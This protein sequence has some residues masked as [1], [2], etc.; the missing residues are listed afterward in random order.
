MELDVVYAD[1]QLVVVNKP[2]GVAVQPDRSGDESLLQRVQAAFPGE[3][4]GSPHRLDRPVGGLVVFTRSAAALRGMDALFRERQVEKVYLAVVEG[5]LEQEG[6]LEHRL[7][8]PGGTRKATVAAAGE[9]HAV[10][11]RYRVRTQGDRYSLL[12]VRPEGGAFHQIRAQ[13]AAA[14]HP[15]KGDVKYG[16]RRGEKDRSIALHAW[17]L[18]FAHPATGAEVLAEAAPPGGGIWAKLMDPSA[19]K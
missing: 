2:P 6:T 13:L 17:R 14:G 5:R 16:A 10:R 11:V 12:E 9:G 4:I 3:H 18:R 8:H 15:I 1:A 7:V 19:G